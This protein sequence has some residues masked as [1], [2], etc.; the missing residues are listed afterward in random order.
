LRGNRV[1]TW[2]N[3]A[4]WPL[5]ICWKKETTKHSYKKT[6]DKYVRFDSGP[7]NRQT[8]STLDCIQVNVLCRHIPSPIMNKRCLGKELPLISRFQV[9]KNKGKNVH[10]IENN[11]CFNFYCSVYDISGISPIKTL[12]R[13]NPRQVT[14]LFFKINASDWLLIKRHYTGKKGLPGVQ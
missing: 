4:I 5:K 14:I 11:N 10:V 3:T 7:L 9:I 1:K 12:S 8:T 2:K 6:F 13:H